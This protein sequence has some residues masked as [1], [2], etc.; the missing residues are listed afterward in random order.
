MSPESP[1]LDARYLAH[2]QAHRGVDGEVRVQ[3]PDLDQCLTDLGSGQV[4]FLDELARMSSGYSTADRLAL[5]DQLML[6]L[7][8]FYVH[9]PMKWAKHAVDPIRALSGLRR[10][11]ERMEDLEFHTA[12][13]RIFKSLRDIHTAY[14]LPDPYRTSVWFLPFTL[15]AYFDPGDETPRIVVDGTLKGFP[16]E[17]FRRGSEV[18]TWNGRA[19]EHAVRA[20]GREESGSNR[21]AQFAN[22]LRMMTIR[23]LGGSIAPDSH[24]V[25]IG[26]LDPISE[27]GAVREYHEIRLSWLQLPPVEEKANAP[28]WMIPLQAA[29]FL[30]ER[31][32]ENRKAAPGGKSRHAPISLDRR[33][34]IVDSISRS[35][36]ERAHGSAERSTAEAKVRETIESIE[37]K[38][39]EV[40]QA[41]RRVLDAYGKPI[42]FGYIRIFNFMVYPAKD[43]AD[44]FARLLKAVP[45]DRLILDLRSNAGGNPHC[46]EEVMQFLTPKKIDPL[47]FEFLATPGADVWLHGKNPEDDP[48]FGRWGPLVRD[49]V[50]N[51]FM[52][53]PSRTLTSSEDANSTGQIYFGKVALLVD[54]ITYSTGDIFT[55]LFKD[56]EVG[57]IIGIS[58]VTGGGGA[59]MME[60]SEIVERAPEESGF[61]DL[62]KGA[63]MHLALRRYLRVGAAAGMPVEEAGVPVDYYHPPTL[64]DFRN[65]DSDLMRSALGALENDAH[66][67]PAT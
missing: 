39:P 57:P 51:G 60:H 2:E 16:V 27:T 23:W 55:A 17:S 46:A 63:K 33:G 58:Q 28:N 30:E 6:S 35:L 4:D 67:T 1:R 15:Q 40:F 21:D 47:P 14:V 62:P 54:A 3:V 50:Y 12:V 56:H 25:T 61:R 20:I 44:E 43:F 38:R 22:G 9:Q 26:Y 52:F 5:V 34:L 65:H 32:A 37:S 48:D 11:C 8:A 36:Y 59:D 66:A 41:G 19:I 31:V 42:E 45:K 29:M 10:I 18:L 49:S 64:E 13:A 7:E 53:S 24:W